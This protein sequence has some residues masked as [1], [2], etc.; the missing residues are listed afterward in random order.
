MY[1]YVN[2]WLYTNTY[3]RVSVESDP[4]LYSVYS[5]HARISN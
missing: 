4:K 2:Y 1:A 5:V 3:M